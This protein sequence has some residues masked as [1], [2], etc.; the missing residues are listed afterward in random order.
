MSG[1][2]SVGRGTSASRPSVVPLPAEGQQ[3]GH[4]FLVGE[5][6]T[7]RPLSEADVDGPYVSWFNDPEV[8][9]FNSH[10]VYPYTREM[11]LDFVRGLSSSR[12]LVLA[13]VSA[14]DGRHLG[15]ISLQEV[16]PL[17]RTAE[18]AIVLGDRRAWGTGVATEAGKLILGHGFRAMNLHRVGAGTS[19]ENEAMKKL[20]VRLG[21]KEEGV[22]RQAM[23]KDGRYHDIV[24]FGVLAEDWFAQEAS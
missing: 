17:H 12:D 2:S 23:F 1:Q 16:N 7:L 10:H 14:E 19:V 24:E 11:A 4:P 3:A 13:M 6:V 21:M 18:F 15:N 5:R 8:C 9:R 20:A 22:R